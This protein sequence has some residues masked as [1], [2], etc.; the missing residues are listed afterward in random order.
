MTKL[1]QIWHRGKAVTAFVLI[2]MALMRL[3]W[4][5]L[6]DYPPKINPRNQIAIESV[7]LPSHAPCDLGQLKTKKHGAFSEGLVE[8]QRS[9][10]LAPLFAPMA[11]ES[12]RSGAFHFKTFVTL[13]QNILSISVFLAVIASRFLTGG[14]M[15]PLVI[16]VVLLSRGRMITGIGDISPDLLI[17][18]F[19]SLYSLFMIHFIRT[20]WKKSLLLASLSG[21]LLGLSE[22]SLLVS[23]LFLPFIMFFWRLSFVGR[24]PRDLPPDGKLLQKY[25]LF[26]FWR[27]LRTNLGMHRFSEFYKGAEEETA[28][29]FSPL[30]MPFSY[31]ILFHKR[32]F[33]L[34]SL[35]L[36]CGFALTLT[37]AYMTGLFEA[38]ASLNKETGFLSLPRETVFVWFKAFFSPID[39]DLLCAAL[40][41][42][43]G[44]L[45]PKD[46][47]LPGYANICAAFFGFLCVACLQSFSLDLLDI[48]Y[49]KVHS[50]T[51]DWL[52]GFRAPRV[53][54]WFEP[55][56]MTLGVLGVLNIVNLFDA[57]LSKK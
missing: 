56:L 46:K 6:R 38:F 34:G 50:P 3:I 24:I 12:C 20:G 43:V 52:E 22:P 55:T 28:R 57:F 21:F 49:L 18:C 9:Y 10:L 4:I 48:L 41:T 11:R 44:L 54:L 17:T 45:S 19:V 40:L 5:Q 1:Q 36:I 14:W 51:A 47:C 26:S 16:S 27:R 30:S 2:V 25:R 42:L 35:S 8:N 53:L 39:L 31:W 15:M 33:L 13:N 37:A 32:W 29:P 7:S 23:C